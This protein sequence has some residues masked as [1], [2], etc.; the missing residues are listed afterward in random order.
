MPHRSKGAAVFIGAATIFV[1][2]S[3]V[4]AATEVVCPLSISKSWL[5]SAQ[6]ELEY[7]AAAVDRF[8]SDKNELPSNLDQVLGVYIRSEGRDPWGNS[9]IYRQTAAAAGYLLYSRGA[10]GIDEGGAGDDVLPHGSTKSYTCAQYESLCVSGCQ[11]TKGVAFV[12]A[13]IA[14]LGIALFA[15]Y[16]GI[17]SAVKRA[18]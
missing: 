18:A 6:F 5:Y 10:N 1:A 9:Y 14:L 12:A 7:L 3:L 16:A 8:R 17:R 4:T 2:G 11:V 13:L 15:T